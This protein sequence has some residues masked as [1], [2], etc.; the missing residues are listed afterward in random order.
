MRISQD[1]R[2]LFIPCLLRLVFLHVSLRPARRRSITRVSAMRGQLIAS[3]STQLCG[4]WQEL[5]LKFLL[6]RIA[7]HDNM[8]ISVTFI[9]KRI[10]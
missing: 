7:R 6:V 8:T 2:L 5:C 4:E 3:S 9:Y 10:S 1:S